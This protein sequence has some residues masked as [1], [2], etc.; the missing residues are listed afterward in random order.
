MVLP[1]IYCIG[2][3]TC[4]EN[5][6][7]PGEWNKGVIRPIPKSD[8][9]DPR[10]PPLCY[11]GICLISIPCKVYADILNVR[12]S[13]WIDENNI[14]VDE[15]NGFRRNRSCLEH[16]YALFTVINKQKQQNNLRL[17]AL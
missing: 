10:D 13:Q 16:I 7:V 4:F 12:F 14:V 3:L 9:N 6:S 8:A 1:S 2:L 17:F 5:G 15:Q 11:I